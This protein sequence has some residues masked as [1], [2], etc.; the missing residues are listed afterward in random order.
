MGN[1]REG[2]KSF[3]V[4]GGEKSAVGNFTMFHQILHFLILKEEMDAKGGK[5]ES[6]YAS[7]N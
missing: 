4:F 7:V 2:I 6:S 5:L 3:D 1:F